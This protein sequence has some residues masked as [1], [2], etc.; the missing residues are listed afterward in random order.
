[1]D[2]HIKF[3]R[4]HWTPKFHLTY[5]LCHDLRVVYTIK[6]VVVVGNHNYGFCPFTLVLWGTQL[7]GLL[8]L[9]LFWFRS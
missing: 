7:V 9:N 6:V 5:F 4:K 3:G 2:C 8:N 1:M